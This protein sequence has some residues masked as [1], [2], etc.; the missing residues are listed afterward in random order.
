MLLNLGGLCVGSPN[1]VFLGLTLLALTFSFD[2]YCTRIAISALGKPLTSSN[3]TPE[4]ARLQNKLLAI[5]TNDKIEQATK[6]F[7][8][9]NDPILYFI[10]LKL[11]RV[12]DSISNPN[13]MWGEYK[14]WMI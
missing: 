14:Q 2:N 13:V 5:T 3:A 8:G 11:R 10:N 1:L 7:F 6:N 9:D 12:H 4:L